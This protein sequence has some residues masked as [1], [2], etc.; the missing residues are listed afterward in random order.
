[1][2]VFDRRLSDQKKA[3]RAVPRSADDPRNLSKNVAAVPR[4]PTEEIISQQKS[5][6]LK[7]EDLVDKNNPM[8]PSK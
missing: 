3:S 5:R 8:K 2:D 7:K 4:P 6:F 1:M